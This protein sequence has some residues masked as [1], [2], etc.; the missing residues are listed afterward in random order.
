MVAAAIAKY[1]ESELKAKDKRGDL[2]ALQNT[3]MHTFDEYSR[4][5]QERLKTN[6][7]MEFI[8]RINNRLSE[9]RRVGGV[10]LR[11]ILAHASTMEI[12]NNQTS[13]LWGKDERLTQIVVRVQSQWFQDAILKANGRHLL[14]ESCCP[15]A[16]FLV[17]SVRTAFHFTHQNTHYA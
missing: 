15:S 12:E 3:Q 16:Q 1:G 11:E 10:L 6:V 9:E 5:R 8:V 4:G 14:V 13:E 2:S 7:G 17:F